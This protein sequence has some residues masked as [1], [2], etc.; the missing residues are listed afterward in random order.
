MIAVVTGGSGFLGARIVAL[1]RARGDAVRVLTRQ[2]HPSLAEMGA[3][4]LSVDVRDTAAVRSA[5]AGSDVI[6][7]VAGRTGHWG[8][9]TAFQSVNV[10]G[11]SS[12]L[13]AAAYAGIPRLVYTSTPSVVGYAAEVENGGPDLPHA[14]VH[15]SA[16][17]ES[18]ATAERLV[19]AANSPRLAT[20]ALRPHLIIGPGDRQMLPRIVRRAAQGRLRIVGDG[21]NRVDLT[22]ID[23]AAWAH[24]DAAEALTG[25]AAGK[26][27]FIS[28]GEP[29][30]LWPWLNQLLE[31]LGLP[32]A[33]RPVPLG[34]ARLVGAASEW[35][36]RSLALDGEP[37]VTRFL[38]S[39][40]ARSHWYDMTPAARDIGYR[41]RIPMAEATRR[42]AQWLLAA[43]LRTQ[44]A[45]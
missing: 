24:L 11:T 31:T 6:Y 45:I 41:I 44:D 4:Y 12:V 9:R 5:I 25:P 33:G 14:A 36:W 28:N 3:A 34:T 37:P 15:E 1:L 21:R 27:Y 17:A 18:K 13:A 19:L 42:T 38:A 16:Y 29:V 40:L 23:N 7:H 39:A 32:P 22:Y 10:D 43:H 30:A 2:P 20:I 35:L 8:A 26:A